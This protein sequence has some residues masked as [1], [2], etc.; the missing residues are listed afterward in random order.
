MA[1]LG[2]RVLLAPCKGVF[3]VFAVSVFLLCNHLRT[4]T[5]ARWLRDTKVLHNTDAVR[6][7]IKR[8]NC[9]QRSSFPPGY[10]YWELQARKLLPA[11]PSEAR[12]L[13]GKLPVGTPR[14]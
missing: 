9:F 7:A 10:K 5:F 4:V 3:N 1:E 8:L 14:P 13:G 6:Q 2:A 11:A 12:R